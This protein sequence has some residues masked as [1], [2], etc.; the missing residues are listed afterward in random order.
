VLWQEKKMHHGSIM[1][2]LLPR[3]IADS[4]TPDHTRCLSCAC[5]LQEIVVI[6]LHSPLAKQNTAFRHEGSLSQSDRLIN[7]AGMV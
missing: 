4:Y 2:T 5:A 6:V 1:S 7:F 3:H